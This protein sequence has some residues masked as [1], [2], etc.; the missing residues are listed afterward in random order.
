MPAAAARPSAEPKRSRSPVDRKGSPE[1]ARDYLSGEPPHAFHVVV[2]P[3]PATRARRRSHLIV[4]YYVPTVYRDTIP[5]AQVGRQL[6]RGAVH[7]RGEPLGV[8]HEAFVLDAY[9]DAVD[10]P[11]ASMPDDVQVAHALGY[12][13]VVRT[14]DVVGGDIRGG[15]GTSL[16]PRTKSPG[17]RG[18][19]S[20]LSAALR[21]WPP[22]S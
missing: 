19:L 10:R 1:C 22:C 6:C 15:V 14:D 18:S 17:S 20:C 21:G 8:V 3:P 9:R 16:S 4:P 13:A 12:L 7:L 2:P 5:P 11:A